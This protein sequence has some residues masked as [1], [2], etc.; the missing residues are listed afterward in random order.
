[1]N[2]RDPFDDP[3]FDRD[4]SGGGGGV[5]PSRWKIVAGGLATIVLTL[6]FYGGL[7]A[8]VLFIALTLLQHFGVLMIGVAL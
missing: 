6:L 1:V 8:V 7:V 5:F 2:G 3:F 4:D